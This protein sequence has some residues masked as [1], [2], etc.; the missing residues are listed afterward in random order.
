MA[1]MRYLG[2]PAANAD[3]VLT[4]RQ[5]DAA[6]AALPGQYLELSRLNLA[7]GVPQLDANARMGN[8][9][10]PTDISRT[11]LTSTGKTTAGSLE[12][13]GNTQLA[14]TTVS[15][16]L[17]AT[18]LSVTNNATVGGTLGVTGAISGPSATLTG[19]VKAATADIPEVTTATF[20]AKATTLDSLS[21]SGLT[22]IAALNTS[23][24]ISTKAIGGTALT[25]TGEAKGATVRA[26]SSL[27]A[28]GAAALQGAVTVG[29]H[30]AAQTVTAAQRITANAGLRIGNGQNITQ[31]DAGDNLVPVN[32]GN[33]AVINGPLTNVTSM[34]TSGAMSVG[35][36]S[37]SG[38]V[39][40]TGKGTF[41]DLQSNSNLQIY[42]TISGV[43]DLDISGDL[44]VNGVGKKISATRIETPAL[45]V[46]NASIA[47]G[48]SKTVGHLSIAD[49]IL[50]QNNSRYE[51]YVPTLNDWVPNALV[52]V[53][54]TTIT[55]SPTYSVPSGS[56]QVLPMTISELNSSTAVFTPNIS[57]GIRVNVA[58]WYEIHGQFTITCLS[59]K[60]VAIGIRVN[61]TVN[62]R[63]TKEFRPGTF[64]S[65]AGAS[66]WGYVTAQTSFCMVLSAGDVIT[67]TAYQAT[68][69]DADIQKTSPWM[70]N[71]I[72][73]WLGTN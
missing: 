2:R 40:A 61:G 67:M 20:K 31:V 27:V 58:G 17:S 11:T 12:V 24:D 65:E 51:R 68:G 16:A 59:N 62:N 42:G 56:S 15:G 73:K 33:G 52:A 60:Q 55:T 45:V 39:N 34:S 9:Y 44:A 72:V 3:D 29:G 48:V 32:F 30:L 35:S 4:K 57:N 26:T 1:R 70:P 41:S 37:V 28:E 64:G 71:L 8:A 50:R 49:T 43:V 54:Q 23:G 25:V 18:S 47:A 22:S 21:V 6:L 38:P 46:T 13:T 10:L 7:N 36:L 14:G 66:G 53:C 69:F 63:G 19:Q 5:L